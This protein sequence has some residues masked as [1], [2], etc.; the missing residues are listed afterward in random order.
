MTMAKLVF[1][2]MIVLFFGLIPLFVKKPK[3][4]FIGL[5]SSLYVF[6]SGWIFYHYNG[7]MLGDI[8]IFILFM[9]A[10]FSGKKTDF[11]VKPIGLPLL[12][13]M[14][15]CIISSVGAINPGWAINELSTYFRMYL[16]IVGIANNIR[17]MQELRTALFGM[18][19]ALLVESLIGI[20]QWR[21]GAVGLYYLGER[22]ARRILW[23]SMG[24]FYV[25][26]F[27][28]NYLALMLPIAFRMFVYYRP[29][30]RMVTFFFGAVFISGIL[31]IFTT[32]GRGPW[33]GL[34]IAITIIVL[35]SALKSRFRSRIRWTIPVLIIFALFFVFRY[36]NAVLSQF[37]SS[38][39]ASAQV[40][41]PQ[42]RIARRM[43]QANPIKGVG[44]GNYELNSWNYMTERERNHPQVNNYIKMVHNVYL[45]I[46][47]ETGIIGG[48]L[49]MVWFAAILATCYRILKSRAINDFIVNL[50]LGIFG[51]ILA[52]IIIFTY[53]PD[54]H[55]YQIL[56][57]IGLFC[58][59]LIAML[60][61]V[62]NARRKMNHSNM[63]KTSKRILKS[64]RNV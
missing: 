59:L 60:H 35:W 49:I 40:R 1:I 5:A 10:I 39:Q 18:F 29:R 27:Y 58:G 11:L 13:F 51:G 64:M 43:I 53:S 41:F 12:L 33:I 46:S 21:F 52:I 38:R 54:I 4:Y 62:Q 57:Q 32:Y 31:A 28:A 3:L 7:I 17:N 8:P 30:K 34:S 42:F 63:N 56:Y 15:W 47:A 44:L 26:S 16:L 19:I 6:S 37:G 24:T 36:H 61:L 14:G 55:E 45:Y 2:L 20:Y 50:A 9:M 23:R 25:P 22:S 48:I